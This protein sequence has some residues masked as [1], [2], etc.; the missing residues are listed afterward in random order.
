MIEHLAKC[1]SFHAP[2]GCRRSGACCSAG[3]TI[4]FNAAERAVVH[5][6][7]IVRGAID[8]TPN[9]A[10][11]KIADGRCT[12]LG[13]SGSDHSCAIHAAG[14][15]AA[16]PLTCRMFPRQVLHDSRGTFISLS[17]FCPTAAGLLFEDN[18]PVGILDAPAALAGDGTLDGLDARDVWPPLLRPGVMMDLDSFSTWERLA[19]ELLTRSGIAPG[20]SLAALHDATERLESWTPDS[21][22]PLERAV[23]DSFDSAAPVP[24]AEP[25]AHDPAVKRWLAARLF[26]S[27][28]AYQGNSLR[29]LVRYLRAC[30]D[31]LQ[32]ELARDGHALEAIR[33]SDRLIIHEAASQQIAT[34]LNDRS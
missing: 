9:G 19:I 23:R 18:G 8:E 12:F 30:L 21:T 22:V 27:W 3:W 10:F 29:T 11:A 25:A 31:V 6:L 16:L 5:T 20:A 17:H 26:G 24:S 1:L 14:G 4:P 34:L 13:G 28:I 33:R 32:V 2:Y 15:H 7:S